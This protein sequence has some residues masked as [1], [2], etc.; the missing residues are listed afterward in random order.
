MLENVTTAFRWIRQYHTDLAK[1][2]QEIEQ[3]FVGRGWESYTNG[4]MDCTTSKML[5]S[6]EM[7]AP[8][9]NYVFF[10]P[11]ARRDVLVTVLVEACILTQT[12]PCV[13]LARFDG[14]Q[15]VDPK[16]I[17][18]YWRNRDQADAPLTWSELEL[19][20]PL[21]GVT[22]RQQWFALANLA[23]SADVAKLVVDP[24]VGLS[25]LPATATPP[26]SG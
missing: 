22:A 3:G 20:G 16:R 14:Q 13:T 11:G 23:G 21:K 18:S 6:P 9:Y 10:Y 1:L 19:G 2:F 17:I 24:L 15:V 26:S 8:A 4:C 5:R 7:W 12:E 25:D